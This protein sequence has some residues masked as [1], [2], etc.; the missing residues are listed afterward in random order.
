MEVTIRTMKTMLLATLSLVAVLLTASCDVTGT[1]P[2]DSAYGQQGDGMN[3]IGQPGY[4][5]P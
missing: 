2:P 4:G 1:A 3:Q 5:S